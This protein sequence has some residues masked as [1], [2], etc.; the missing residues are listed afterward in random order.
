MHA[1]FFNYLM[2]PGSMAIIGASERNFYSRNA[3]QRLQ[4]CGYAGKVHLVNP[5]TSE[6]FGKRCHANVKDIGESIDMALV[7]VPRTAVIGALRDCVEAGAKAAVVVSTGFGESHDAVGLALQREL[8][9]FLDEHPIALCGP[10]CLGVVNM[11]DGFQAFGGHP[12][13]EILPG[14]IGLVSQSGANVHSYI[15]AAS[16]RNL[17]FSYVVSS[18]NEAGMDATD[19]IDCFLRDPD[20]KVVCAYIESFKSSDALIRVA[21]QALKVSKPLIVIKI[22]R[23]PS[24]VRA[25]LAHTG[26]MTGPDHYFDTLFRQY[27]IIRANTIEE[28][29]DRACIFASSQEAYWPSGRRAGV[30]SVSGGFAATLS[31]LSRDGGFDVPELDA[32]SVRKLLE[33]LPANVNPQNPIDISTQVRRDRSDAWERTVNCMA[34]DPNVDFVLNGEAVPLD[35]DRLQELTSIRL[36]TGK[37]VLLASTSP[38]IQIL[39]DAQRAWCREHRLPVVVGVE[40]CHRAIQS[41]LDFTAKVVLARDSVKRS[42]MP[43]A[44]LPRPA[45]HVLHEVKARELLLRFGIRGPESEC[46]SDASE[47]SSAAARI[48]GRLAVKIVSDSITHRTDRG[49][50]HLNVSPATAFEVASEI[51]LRVKQ[52]EPANP[53]CQILV[54]KMV[55][56]GVAELFIG[57]TRRSGH[58]P[59]LLVG[60]GG[61]LVELFGD[62]VSRICPVDPV[63]AGEMLRELRG[64][65]LLD[66]FRGRPKADLQSVIRT[67]CAMSDFAM[68][69]SQWLGEAEINPLIVLPEGRGAL[70]VDALVVVDSNES[71]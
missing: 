42:E 4:D 26:A 57:V 45:G 39:N 11:I 58:R 55:E 14:S 61:I 40:G 21:E 15:G 50:V 1:E 65:P 44:A 23:S 31:D 66:G 63:Q 49:L 56:E 25:A 69:A 33:V 64:F 18:G 38:H 30:V 19:Y 34:D 68:A 17:G 22:G 67:L 46:V 13:T 2:A 52:E 71:H 20:T 47:A 60:M 36:R 8:S 48:G 43:V 9:E 62:H 29:L 6:V 70:A 5:G 24:A 41:T 54:Q 32:S 53:R 10:S 28:S 27:G 35:D 12:G 37:P 51:E 3:L 7:V 16:A 59:T